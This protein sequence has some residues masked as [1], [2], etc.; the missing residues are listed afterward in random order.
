MQ[1]FNDLHERHR[2]RQSDRSIC[3]DNHFFNIEHDSHNDEQKTSL[4]EI[5]HEDHD[6]LR[7]NNET[8]SRSER[9]R[10]SFQKSSHRHIHELS[11]CYS[12]YSVLQETVRSISAV[13]INQKKWTMRSRNAHSLN[14]RSRWSF[15]QWSNRH[16]C[17]KDDWMKT[18]RLRFIDFRHCQLKIL[19]SAIK[20]EIRIR[21]KIEWTETW[22][23][24]IIKRI[25]H[26]IIKKL[27]KN[28]LMKFKKMTRSRNAIIVQ[29][30]TNKIELKNYFHQIKTIESSRCLCKVRRQTMHHTLLKCSKFD[31]LREKM[32]ADKLETVEK[33]VVDEAI[34]ISWDDEMNWWDNESRT[35]RRTFLSKKN[36]FDQMIWSSDLI[37]WILSH[38]IIIQFFM[39]ERFDHESHL[40]IW[41][42]SYRRFFINLLISRR[43]VLRSFN[44][45]DL[46]R[47]RWFLSYLL[48]F[49]IVEKLMSTKMSMRFWWDQ[50]EVT[51]KLEDSLI[52]RK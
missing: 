10:E 33:R 16:S 1:S 9:N 35:T 12:S 15:R 28:V 52:R 25:T 18:I 49:E 50:I 26:R 6:L 46:F 44:R 5:H 24:I 41:D 31:D 42:D 34:I 43:V 7:R 4:F 19:I 11:S 8:W 37:D 38:Y 27:I 30:R 17:Q 51:T 3:D 29:V 23:I 14:L 48:I 39:H 45:N 21:A 20:N 22:R 32:W 40:L 2:H 47:S 13:N 36:L